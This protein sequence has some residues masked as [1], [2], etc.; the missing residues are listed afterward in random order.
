MK[1]NPGGGAPAVNKSNSTFPWLALSFILLISLTLTSCVGY[2]S[3]SVAAGGAGA[4]Q[5][6]DPGVSD[7]AQVSASPA[8]VN[9]GTLATGNSNS[10]AIKLTNGGSATLTLSQI[11]VA[12]TGFSQSGLSTSTTIAAGDSVTFDAIFTPSSA[13]A[14]SGSITLT[15]NGDPS[16]LV[17]KLS[18][19]GSSA[20]LLLAANPTSLNFGGVA[21]GSQASQ[22]T[23]LTNNGNSNVTISAVSV[24]GAG[25]T[26][27]GVPEG[28]VLTPGQSATLTVTFAPTAAGTVSGAQVRVASNAANSPTVVTLS[29]TGTHSVLLQWIASPT[30]NVTYNVYRGTSPGKEGTTPVN[31]SVV[32]GTAYTD[33]NVS[34]GQSYSYV[35]EAVNSAG[36]SPAS[37]EVTVT[38]PNP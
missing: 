6:A 1:P 7:Q 4:A 5:G 27:S 20:S 13:K 38:I 15:T 14:V 25:F 11:K 30:P 22:T 10:Q 17:I 36:S 2:T 31:S 32:S 18:G 19:T 37:N 29:G 24:T 28:T 21:D 23:S 16:S 26:A 9:F 35:V 33:T 8:S 34:S 3:S 12:G